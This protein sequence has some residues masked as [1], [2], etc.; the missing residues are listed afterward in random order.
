MFGFPDSYVTP[1]D[2]KR[3]RTEL[4][5]K[6]CT[7]ATNA[8]DRHRRWPGT[9]LFGR[10]SHLRKAAAPRV[11]NVSSGYG[12]LDGMSANVPRYCLSKLAL[13]GVTIMLAAALRAEGVAV[14]SMCP[15]WVRTDMGGPDAT[16]SVEEG[17]DTAVWLADEAPR[18]LTGKFF[19]SR[20]E[21]A[22]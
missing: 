20:A 5:G 18:E 3:Q 1:D 22:W 15:G 21:I 8:H 7:E 12:Q 11:I 9:A 13:N 19:R 17:A 4:Y 16:R 14:N 6:F 10:R 2:P